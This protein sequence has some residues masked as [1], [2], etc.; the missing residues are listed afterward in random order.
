MIARRARAPGAAAVGTHH[1]T[2]GVTYLGHRS[3][4]AVAVAALL[5]AA[6]GSA[7][8]Q[9]DGAAQ[10]RCRPGAVLGIASITDRAIRSG[11]F[12]STYSSAAGLFDNRFNCNGRPVLVRRQSPGVYDVKFVG[13]HGN[14]LVGNVSGNAAGTLGWGRHADGSFTIYLTQLGTS[15]LV[16]SAFVVTLL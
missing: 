14:V 1:I 13:N 16:D 3:A 6:V 12:P 5:L 15:G 7:F 10:K 9:K 2:R 8:V 4:F 11:A